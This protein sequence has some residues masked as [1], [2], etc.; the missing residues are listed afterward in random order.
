[1]IN[2]FNEHYLENYTPYW[3]SCLDDSMNYFLDKF[4]PGFISVL[5][6]P[7][8]LGNEYHSIA[9]G[10]EGNTVMYWIKIQKGKDRPKYA[11]GKWAFPSN[12]E[13]ENTNTG[14]KYTKTSILMCEMTVPLHITG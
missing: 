1:M 3:L 8:P 9:D 7:H 4:F 11:N 13:G 12:F 6:K 2:N 5:R 10:D 14:R